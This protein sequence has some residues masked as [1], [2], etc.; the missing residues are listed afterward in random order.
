M[1]FVNEVEGNE[2]MNRREL[3]TE[4]RTHPRTKKRSWPIQDFEK[5]CCVNRRTVEGRLKQKGPKLKSNF[6]FCRTRTASQQQCNAKQPNRLQGRGGESI[7]TKWINGLGIL[8]RSV[9]S[10]ICWTRTAA[11]AQKAEAKQ[12]VTGAGGEMIQTK[13]NWDTGYLLEVSTVDSQLNFCWTR[14]QEQQQ[15]HAEGQKQ[16]RWS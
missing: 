15:P 9:D 10:Q 6:R 1:L 3:N 12:V 16:N 4:S 2:K 5:K 8:T 14:S 13:W 7:Q 11:T